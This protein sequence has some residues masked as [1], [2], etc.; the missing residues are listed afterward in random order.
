MVLVWTS[1]YNGEI[2]IDTTLDEFMK[3]VAN[4]EPFITK[5]S[6][7]NSVM[8]N[9]KYITYAQEVSTDDE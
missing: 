6:F 2:K 8:F 5:D 3:A 7:G 1:D 4:K 9:P